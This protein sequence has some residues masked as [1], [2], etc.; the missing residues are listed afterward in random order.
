MVRY[1]LSFT[2]S[3]ISWAGSA[4][5]ATIAISI[6]FFLTSFSN[7]LIFRISIPALLFPIFPGSLSKTATNITRDIGQR[8]YQSVAAG[9]EQQ[10]KV[11][12]L[13][14]SLAP[15][16]QVSTSTDPLAIYTLLAQALQL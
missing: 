15:L 16:E 7:S 13:L 4:G 12:G 8:G 1:F 9:L 6:C 11:P 2:L 3:I 10:L 14:A 5:T